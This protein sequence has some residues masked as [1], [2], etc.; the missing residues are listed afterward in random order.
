M[1]HFF[2]KV[3]QSRIFKIF[4]IFADRAVEPDP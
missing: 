4:T 1:T 3:G 2:K